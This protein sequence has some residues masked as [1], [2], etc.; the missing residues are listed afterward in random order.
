[1]RW[2]HLSDLHFSGVQDYD[3]T[4]MRDKLLQYIKKIKSEKKDTKFDYIIL[5]GDFRYAPAKPAAKVDEV[6]KYIKQIA[7]AG[8]TEIEN[9][10][11]VP[12][13]HDLQRN[14]ARKGLIQLPTSEKY[15][16]GRF[17]DD[18]GAALQHDFEFFNLIE[19][20]LHGTL[21][22][23]GKLHRLLKTKTLNFLLLNTAITAGTDDDRGRLLLG[24]QDID[25]MLN[26]RDKTIPT[27]VVG[28]H[29]VSYWDREEQKKVLR[30]FHDADI[31]L[32]LCGHE[33]SLYGEHF[34][35]GLRQITVGCIASSDPSENTDIGFCAGEY[36]NGKVTLK[37]YHWDERFEWN[38]VSDQIDEEIVLTSK[39]RTT[40]NDRF[41]KS[42]ELSPDA[43]K[44][45]D[46]DTL[47]LPPRADNFRLDG[48]CLISPLGKD[49]IKYYWRKGEEHVESLTF[50]QRVSEEAKDKDQANIDR[51]T[52]SYTISTSIS[53]MLSAWQKQCR[54]CAT[55]SRS[56]KGFLT[57]EEIALQCIFMA[58]YDSVCPGYPEVRY[59]AREFSFM[60]QGEPGFNY[61]SIREAIKLTDYAMEKINQEVYRYVIST[62][63]VY[64][65]MPSLIEDIQK[66]IFKNKVNIHF[67]LHAI[68]KERSRLMPINEDYDYETFLSY[69]REL[70]A[71]T[72]EKIGVGILMIKEY[73]PPKRAGEESINPITLTEDLLSK[74]LEKLDP[75]VFRIDLSVLNKTNVTENKK[76]MDAT[77]AG[78]LLD[79]ATSM[80]FEA[81]LFTSFGA[82]Q[83]SGCGML[84]SIQVD[85]EE[86]GEKTIDVFNKA[87][88]LLYYSVHS[89]KSKMH[90]ESSIEQ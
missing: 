48:H 65:F 32:Y 50:N 39:K 80:G 29:G 35:E 4:K 19:K 70:F 42:N 71:V 77:E 17:L 27:V 46:N 13:N 44:I 25:A 53:C 73:V 7:D 51:N 52:S 56:F 22:S 81:K 15:K 34:G 40:K 82:S 33:H 74:I 88:R 37:Y 20:Q 61:S 28:H 10:I 9:V 26:E 89:L 54:F 5:A 87:R 14:I 64:D 1:M 31:R 63:G 58:L 75:K 72:G 3:T 84:N 78:K 68:D 60:G 41:S 2:L 57:A 11:C 45:L 67:S 86:D 12:G 6:I 76:T 90:P 21:S 8:G 59:H 66:G 30:H 36:S 43:I 16:N 83:Q 79:K 62:C 23:S 24:W 47:S 85:A 18:A 69:C 38:P 49:G 55:G